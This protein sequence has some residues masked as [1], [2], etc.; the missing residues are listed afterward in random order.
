MKKTVLLFT[1]LFLTAVGASAQFYLNFYIYYKAYDGSPLQNVE[2]V[3]VQNADSSS[4][5]VQFSTVYSQTFPGYFEDSV[6]I[7]ANYSGNNTITFHF[8]DCNGDWLYDTTFSPNDI[9]LSMTFRTN[10]VNPNDCDA[11]FSHL[12]N[13]LKEGS[14][15]AKSYPSGYN[16]TWNFGNGQSNSSSYN[17]ST[18]YSTAGNYLVTHILYNTSVGCYD[19]VVVPITVYDSCYADFSYVIDST[20]QAVFTSTVYPYAN[21]VFW[22]FG[23]GSYGTTPNPSHTYNQPNNYTVHFNMHGPG[24]KDSVTKVITVNSSPNCD[25]SFSHSYSSTPF[26]INFSRNDSSYGT[27]KWTIAGNVV[28]TQNA[29]TWTAPGQGSYLVQL[30]VLD[31]VGTAV[32][33]D[34]LYLNVN[35]C[36]TYYGPGYINGRVSFAGVYRSDYDS[37]RV[38]LIEYDSAAGTLTGI[39]SVTVYDTDTG[40]YFFNVCDYNP[41]YMVKAAL[42][43]GSSLYSD[44]LPCYHDSSV[45]W[46]GATEL[47]LSGGSNWIYAGINLIA[48]TN[49]GGPGFIGGYISQGANK[50]GDALADIE[51]L[52]YD[53]QGNPVAFTMSG[54]AG[55]YEFD[56]L[57]L[58]SYRVVVEIA[59]KPSDIHFVTLTS[60]E[61]SV[62]G[63]NFEVNKEYVSTLNSVSPLPAASKGIYPNPVNDKLFIEWSELAGNEVAVEVL[64]LDGKSLITRKV[65]PQNMDYL[66]LGSL[67][68][69]TYILRLTGEGSQSI[70]RFQKISN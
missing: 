34:N 54:A 11:S 63:R 7:P 66:D 10:C 2:L 47:F 48:G 15:H 5:G 40:Y 30:D 38:Y 41:R 64:S 69:G 43:P 32:C 12:I 33:W 62:D 1:L 46:S 28:S 6:F 58:G 51:V 59:G 8:K 52:L 45:S 17:V 53:D 18:Q 3:A 39:D 19:S 14:F 42:L 35:S 29:F 37:L 49:P 65:N 24:C 60:D 25:A 21:S 70:Y 61:P 26:D 50:N 57:A 22:D 31:S 23:D 44:Y 13:E 68:N 27:A 55:R 9:S 4:A 67:E 36:G 16:Q 20:N 56:N